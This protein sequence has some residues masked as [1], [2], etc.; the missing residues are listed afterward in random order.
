MW[1]SVG[2]MMSFAAVLELV[3]LV[4]YLVLIFGGKQRRETGWRVLVFLLVL[5]GILQVSSMAIVVC[6]LW[7]DLNSGL[8]TYRHM[9]TTTTI[10]FSMAG[11]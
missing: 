7:F 3:T 1:R 6:F 8:I 4:T 9:S 11:S 2:F 5:V 10:D